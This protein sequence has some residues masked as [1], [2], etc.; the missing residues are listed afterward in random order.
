MTGFASKAPFACATFKAIYK[1][2][3]FST[4]DGWPPKAPVQR[5]ISFQAKPVGPSQP[6]VRM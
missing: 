1:D 6:L 5:S 4:A 3:G 2:I